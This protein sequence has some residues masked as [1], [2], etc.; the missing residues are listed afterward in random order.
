MSREEKLNSYR[1]TVTIVIA[2]IGLVLSFLIIK[3]FLVALI[4]AAV[5]AYLFYPFYKRLRQLFPK[6]LPRESFSAALTC[7][8]II[9]IILI[10]MIFMAV[11]LTNE[12]KNGYQFLQQVVSAPDFQLNLPPVVR[13]KVGDL[14]QYKGEFINLGK[15]LVN[16]L[17]NIL[18]SIPHVI[19]SIFITIFSIYF[20]LKGGKEINK[21]IQDFLP[22]PEGRY[23]QIFHRFDDLSRGMIMGQIVVGAIQGILAGVAFYFLNVPNPVLWGFL[24]AIISMIPLLGAALVWGPIDLYLWFV[25][26]STGVFWPAIFLFFYG[27][28]VI[29]TIDNLLKPKIVGDHANVH[30]LIVL[31]GILGGIEL[32]GLPGILIGPMVLTLFDVIMEMFRDLS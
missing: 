9:L 2:I 6:Y 17:Q 1:R 19:L 12:A 5:L 25:G 30:P 29:S 24:T 23:N 18:K 7:L 27:W 16:W 8:V 31:F 22:L 21:F 13:E 3:P 10:P 11:L 14:T 26:Y 28:L 32:I 4:S 15:Q 20:F